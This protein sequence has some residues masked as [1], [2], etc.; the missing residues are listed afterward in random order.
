MD[1]RIKVMYLSGPITGKPDY[2][3]VF[4][5][6]EAALKSRGYIV[7]NPAILPEGMPHE[8]YMPICLAMLAQAD[9]IVMLNGWRESYG[10]V[11]ERDYAMYQEKEVIYYNIMLRE[12]YSNGQEGKTEHSGY[13]D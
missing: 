3:K 9:A 4:N 5:L 12:G 1:E 2:K 8:A 6:A 7:L 13:Q 11:F 10:A